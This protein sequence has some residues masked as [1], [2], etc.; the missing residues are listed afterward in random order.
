MAYG[1]EVTN[2]AG[3]IVLDNRPLYTLEHSGVYTVASGVLVSALTASSGGQIFVRPTTIGA[4]IRRSGLNSLITS[5]GTISYVIVTEHIVLG[6]SSF[7][8]AIYDNLNVPTLVFS[9]TM[10]FIKFKSSTTIAAYPASITMPATTGSGVFKYISLDSFYPTS[11]SLDA[12]HNTTITFQNMSFNTN[13]SIISLS[14]VAEF[15]FYYSSVFSASGLG[16]GSYS[17]SFSYTIIEC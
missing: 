4:T 10:K 6:P 13:Q 8:L 2:T 1:I 7:G 11:S 15:Y 17:R 9:E 5:S 14:S 16:T 3:T 12:N